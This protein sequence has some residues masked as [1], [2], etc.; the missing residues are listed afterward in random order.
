MR[1]CHQLLIIDS[2]TFMNVCIVK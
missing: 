2:R 1:G